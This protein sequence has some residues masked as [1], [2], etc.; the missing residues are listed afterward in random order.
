MIKIRSFAAVSVLSV[1]LLSGCYVIPMNSGSRIVATANTSTTASV[2][3]SITALPARLYPSNDEAQRLGMINAQVSV[4]QTGHGTFSAFIG[5]EQYTGDATRQVNSRQGKANGSAASGR[6][7]V[8][9]Y[10]MNSATLGTGTCR[11]STG[12]TFNM[13]IA[14]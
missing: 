7:I 4:D 11:T 6:Y 9:D 3:T 8:C 14:R 13:Y 1:V 10:S 2:S 12:A 5:G